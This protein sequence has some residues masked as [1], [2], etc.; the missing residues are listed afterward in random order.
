MV[1][2]FSCQ[3]EKKLNNQLRNT[4]AT[5]PFPFPDQP[6]GGNLRQPTAPVRHPVSML[7]LT[8]ASSRPDL[9]E[10]RPVKW[11]WVGLGVALGL[12]GLFLG[13]AVTSIGA[14]RT[15]EYA[16]DMDIS[17]HRDAVLI[18]IAKVFNVVGGPTF[19]PFLLLVLAGLIWWRWDRASAIWFYGLAAIG[20][21]SVTFAKV[22]V[23]RDRPPTSAIHALVIEKAADSFPSG[24]TALA[25]G[26]VFGAAMA[27]RHYRGT[28]RWA[29]IL[30][31]PFLA[32]AAASRM[33]LG[34]HY[35]ADVTAAPIIAGG[36]ILAFSGLVLPVEGRIR[37][38]I[39]AFKRP[40]RARG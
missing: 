23:H 12:L 2:R 8:R 29:L 4:F 19:A 6:M 18:T 27:L 3:P 20:W 35:L 24:H 40:A 1:Y 11:W 15:G 30:G 31:L 16:L 21:V 36:A 39:T 10:P 25:V 32:L 22:L 34:A 28:A 26:V 38:R 7:A 13:F 17:Q 5:K 37:D 14:R 9:G 33:V